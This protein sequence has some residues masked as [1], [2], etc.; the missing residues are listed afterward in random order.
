MTLLFM[1]SLSVLNSC[2]SDITVCECLKDDGS[3]KEECD[4]LG[5]SMTEEELSREM[6]ACN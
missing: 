2:S 1:G 5:R 4:E 6:N 3:H